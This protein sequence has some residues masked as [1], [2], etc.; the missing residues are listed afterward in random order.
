MPTRGLD[1]QIVPFLYMKPTVI[2]VKTIHN[3]VSTFHV[4]FLWHDV[5]KNEDYG[6]TVNVIRN[7]RDW[8]KNERR[9]MWRGCKSV[10]LRAPSHAAH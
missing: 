7:W 6:T 4:D 2:S 9:K 10:A 3:I 8:Q 5:S 1:V